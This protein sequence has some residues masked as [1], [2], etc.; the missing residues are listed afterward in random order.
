MDR[1]V[2]QLKALGD[3]NRFR[4]MMMLRERPLC[5]CEL[6]AVLDIAGGTLSAHLRVLRESG[7]LR[8]EKKGRWVQCSIADQN[9]RSL[10]DLLADRV[11]QSEVFEDDRSAVA[12]MPPA[13]D[14]SAPACPPR[15][16]SR[17]VPGSATRSAPRS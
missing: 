6:L 10:V 16:P 5:S 3:E 15:A 11:L 1:L 2:G 4:I 8:Q 7:L 14:A 12:A 17:T 9:A 13:T